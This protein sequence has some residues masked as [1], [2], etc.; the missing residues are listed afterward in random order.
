MYISTKLQQAL[1][2]VSFLVC[3]VLESK[4]KFNIIAVA[5]ALKRPH[6][7]NI[8]L[9]DSDLCLQLLVILLFAL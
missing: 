6:S 9:I 8:H 5:K 4:S 7:L 2:C 3:P 1:I